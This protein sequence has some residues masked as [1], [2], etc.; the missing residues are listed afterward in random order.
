MMEN[1][2]KPAYAAPVNLQEEFAFG[3][4]DSLSEGIGF[5]IGPA[6]NI[7][8]IAVVFYFLF[9]AFK[10]MTAA[11]N[12]DETAKAQ[13]MITHS[14]IGFLLLMAVFLVLQFLPEFFGLRGF[15]IIK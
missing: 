6:F 2:I 10:Y 12:K 14:L 3:F 15:K 7:A 8:A 1:F 5:L 11:G 4:I 13:A 9:A